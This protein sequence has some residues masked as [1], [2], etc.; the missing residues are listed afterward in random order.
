MIRLRRKVSK[1]NGRNSDLV[2][3]ILLR[4]ESGSGKNHLGRVIAAH[5]RWL[6]IRGTNQDPRL[7]AGIEAFT[8]RFGEIHLPGLNEN[9]IES[10]LFGYRRGAFTDAKENRPGLLGG[11]GSKKEFKDILLDEVGDASP[12][13]QAKIL[14]VVE[15]GRF[16]AVGAALDDEYTTSARLLMATNRNLEAM[17]RK[18]D[19]RSD[20]YWRAH[21]FVITVPPLREQPENI[22]PIGREIERELRKRYIPRSLDTESGGGLSDSD[23]KW[24]RRY[25]WPGNVRELR[26][27]IT[28][29]LLEEGTL[30]LERIVEEMQT[31]DPSMT[32]TS[33]ADE[34]IA[35]LVRDRLAA[36]SEAT[37][38]SIGTLNDLVKEFEHSVKSEANRWYTTARPTD[39]QLQHIFPKHTSVAS[40]RNKLSQ[41]RKP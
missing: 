20:L 2:R 14:G 10:E 17:V 40:I 12:A 8:D 38:T 41:W 32:E 36:A 31:E 19:F 24:A 30:S 18:G 25:G 9:L 3:A 15:H 35:A 13:L 23:F 22:E 1:L 26:H 4:G 33:N 27:A 39:E 6:E 16:R 37:G 28:R 5:R 29:W 11:E 7:D 21:L 34:S